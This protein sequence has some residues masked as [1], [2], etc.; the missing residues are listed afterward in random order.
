MSSADVCR[1]PGPV[2]VSATSG[3]I[4]SRITDDTGCGSVSSPWLLEASPGQRISV[5]LLDFGWDP[6][7]PADQAPSSHCSLYGY[8]SERSINVNMTLCGGRS[9]QSQV[10]TSTSGFLQIQIVSSAA[11][12][13]NAHFLLQYEGEE[14]RIS[15]MLGFQ[16]CLL[17]IVLRPLP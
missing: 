11:A 4:S 13:E 14:L 15:L 7:L 3:F 16:R 10:Y 2:K 8:I 5:S 9:R 1:T 6:S 17:C 12:R